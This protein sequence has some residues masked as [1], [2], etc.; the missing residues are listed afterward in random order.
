MYKVGDYIVYLKEVS[1]IKEI[2]ENFIK[3]VNYYVL[4]PVS[5]S[6]LKLNIPVSSNSIRNLITIDK[7]NELIKEIPFI[8]TID[9]DD[10][11]IE[12]EYKKLLNTG[13]PENLIKIIKT[14]YLRNQDRLNN[15]KKISDKD[16]NYFELAEKYLY[17]EI[18]IVLN[19]SFEDTKNYIINEVEKELS[20]E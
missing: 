7:V 16:R 14:T 20:H 13:T 3:D 4:E 18:S 19:K 11:N 9:I 6:S 15:K 2:K 5:D 1:K 10:K 17:T 12:F 8:D